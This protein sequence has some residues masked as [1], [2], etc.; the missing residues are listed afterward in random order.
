MQIV[1]R[2]SLGQMRPKIF[3]INVGG[4]IIY[5]IINYLLVILSA[6]VKKWSFKFSAIFC[7]L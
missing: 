3:V 6:I 7:F 4:V 5:V 2:I 1:V